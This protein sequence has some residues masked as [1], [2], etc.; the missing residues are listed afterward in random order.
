M[1]YQRAYDFGARKA[2]RDFG[3]TKEAQY[4]VDPE[5]GGDLPEDP[6]TEALIEQA[7]MEEAAAA[8]ADEDAGMEENPFAQMSD[9]EI[10]EY[11]QSLPP[12]VLEQIL[13]ELQA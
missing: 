12:E 2:L 1:S 10:I 13:A 8:A 11:L 9:E 3:F 6:E 7:L 5:T 4:V